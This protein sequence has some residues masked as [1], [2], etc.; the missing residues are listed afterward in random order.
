[1]DCSAHLKKAKRRHRLRRSR[2]GARVDSMLALLTVLL[3]VLSVAS[4]SL[5]LWMV[6][7]GQVEVRLTTPRLGEQMASGA[8]S[9]AQAVRSMITGKSS[10]GISGSRLLMSALP[11]A[12][13]DEPPVLQTS[14]SAEPEDLVVEIVPV[15]ESVG[16]V[17]TSGVAA[18]PLQ[19]VYSQ[20][21]G[22]GGGW[23][24]G[25]AEELGEHSSLGDV[26]LLPL[27]DLK[28]VSSAWLMR[29]D[30]PSPAGAVPGPLA[31]PSDRYGQRIHSVPALGRPVVQGIRTDRS[32]QVPTV[33][34]HMRVYGQDPVVAI[35]HTH[36]SEAY[37]A[38]QGAAYLWGSEDGVVSVGEALAEA[39]WTDYG[40]SVVHSKAFHDVEEFRNAYSRSAVTAESMVKRYSNL[41]LVLDIHRDAT[42]NDSG[43]TVTIGGIRVAQVLL[44]VT[45]DKYGLPHPQWRRN[46][47]AAQKLD[48]V[49]SA[50][51]PGLSRGVRQRDDGRFNQ[52]LH[53]GCI[54]MEVGDVN[55]DKEEAVNA[56]K[57]LAHAI[58][59]FLSTGT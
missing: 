35:Y 29:S 11:S 28:P 25:P 36:S 32:L 41:K 34:G 46:L 51:Y 13:F 55:N 50:L 14:D 33:I 31:Q 21:P 10:L 23:R 54:L 27:F 48:S 43:A 9:A 45:T 4:V 3:V 20:L 19:T 30:E 24:T 40:V 59:V 37:Q 38:S 58:A 2:G 17:L 57:L 18:N 52:H 53:P 39:L 7:T 12:G 15:L 6:G 47:A 16:E 56:A 5:C 42:G 44:L 22:L 1:M 26:R 49:I 8:R